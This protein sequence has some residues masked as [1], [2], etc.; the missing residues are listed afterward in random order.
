L[1]ESFIIL[2]EAQNTTAEQM[3]MVLTR[4]GFNSKMV[5]TGDSTQI[6]LP[7]GRR[8]GLVEAVDVLR[9]VEGISFIQF[10]DR[11][12]VRHALVQRIVKAYERYQESTGIGRQLALKLGESETPAIPRSSE[13]DS[14]AAADTSS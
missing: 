12:V 11:D 10:D 13:P 8:C 3:K 5:V 9:G 1:N 2:D 4:Q 14:P 6:D 7:T